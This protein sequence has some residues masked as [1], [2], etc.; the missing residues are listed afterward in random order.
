MCGNSVDEL[1]ARIKELEASVE[2]LT[3][4]LV[5]CKVRVRELE[6]AVD[7]DLPGERSEE[8]AA[9]TAE[10]AGEPQT[11]DAAERSE[12]VV[13]EA[14]GADTPNTEA[15]ED[16]AEDEAEDDSEA[17]EDSDIIVA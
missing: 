12:I 4:E 2:G 9:G 5:E 17:V 3:D 14:G 1:E 8:S 15:V 11:A 6:A 10:A 16:G 7:G 13:P